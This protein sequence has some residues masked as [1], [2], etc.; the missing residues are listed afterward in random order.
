MV[1]HAYISRVQR[2]K[3]EGHKFKSSLNYLAR[4]CLRNINFYPRKTF[5][6]YSF[7]EASSPGNKK[8]VLCQGPASPKQKLKQGQHC[9]F[10][11]LSNYF[12]TKCDVMVQDCSPSTRETEADVPSHPW[13]YT[14]FEASLGHVNPP[15]QVHYF[16][17]A[18]Q[19]RL[20]IGEGGRQAWTSPKPRGITYRVVGI[21]LWF[22]NS[23]FMV[24][25]F[26][27]NTFRKKLIWNFNTEIR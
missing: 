25:I 14:E 23:R 18:E 21:F 2:M 10:L 8:W 13:P 11:V 24:C 17:I 3:Q 9:S 15:P 12:S 20:R 27:Q 4:S 1:I 19:V 22:L 6:D 16:S 7:S 5:Y 26:S